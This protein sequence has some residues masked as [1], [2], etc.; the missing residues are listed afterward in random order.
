MQT[1]RRAPRRMTL[2]PGLILLA[3][4]AGGCSGQSDVLTVSGQL[5]LDG[6][7]SEGEILIEPIAQGDTPAPPPV[8]VFAESDGTFSATVARSAVTTSVETTDAETTDAG[9]AGAETTDAGTAD[10]IS[11]R[12]VLRVSPPS[13]GDVPAALDELSPPEKTVTLHR[14]LHDGIVLSLIVTH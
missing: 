6:I 8:T 2:K 11:C 9:T 7:P 14:R 13:D 5:L 12:I 3:L 1:T 10:G 4:V